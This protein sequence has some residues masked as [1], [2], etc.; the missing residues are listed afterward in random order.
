MTSKYPTNVTRDKLS[1]DQVLEQ[2]FNG[3]IEEADLTSAQGEHYE[4]V[5]ACYALL[6]KGRTHRDIHKKLGKMFNISYH[7]IYRLIKSTEMLFGAQRINKE[8]K[9]HIAANMALQAFNLAVKQKDNAG[10]SRAVGAYIKATGLENEDPD[11]PDFEKL[12]PS[13]ILTVLPDHAQKALLTMLKGGV[14]DLNT[15]PDIQDAEYEELSESER[16]D[17]AAD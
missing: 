2:L 8:I 1:N 17:Q 10:M 12:Q 13:L 6:L 4:R 15:M 14:V 3:E 7:T 16:S 11:L 5:K 9:R